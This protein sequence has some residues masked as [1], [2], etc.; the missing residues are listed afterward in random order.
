MLELMRQMAVSIAEL[1][2]MADQQAALADIL[3]TYDAAD[4]IRRAAQHH[5][6]Q[7][8]ELRLVLASLGSHCAAETVPTPTVTISSFAP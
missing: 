3:T 8:D 5:R 6:L 1:E 2:A 4:A 7:A